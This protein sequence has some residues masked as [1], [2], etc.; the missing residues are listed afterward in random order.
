MDCS[1]PGPSVYGILQAR[2][3]EGDLLDLGIK[4]E[5]PAL[6]GGLFTTEPPEKPTGL[7]EILEKI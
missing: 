3:L 4:P 1:P 2:I 5:S 6:A 7:G